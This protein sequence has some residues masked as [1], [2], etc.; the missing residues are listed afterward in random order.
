MNFFRRPKTLV[1]HKTPLRLQ[2]E[3]RECGAVCLGI[4]LA[5]Y[6]QYIPMDELRRACGTGRDGVLLSGIARAAR[7][8]GLEARILKQVESHRLYSQPLPF[9]IYWNFNHFLV[10]EGFGA[11]FLWVNDPVGGH[12]RLALDAEFEALYSGLV[13]HFQ[14][15]PDFQRGG[16]V[17]RLLPRLLAYLRPAGG[18]ILLWALLAALAAP[19]DIALWR[20]LLGLESAIPLG[21]LFLGRLGGMALVSILGLHIRARLDQSPALM[22]HL[23]KLPMSFYSA[24]YT[25]EISERGDLPYQIA[26]QVR[27]ALLPLLLSLIYAGGLILGLLLLNPVAGLVAGALAAAYGCCLLALSAEKQAALQQTG[28]WKA[29]L[30]AHNGALSG[31]EAIRQQGS[32]KLTQARIRDSLARLYT[33]EDKYARHLSPPL[34]LILPLCLVLASPLL[35]LGSLFSFGLGV[36]ILFSLSPWYKF[37]AVWLSLYRALERWEDVMYTP[38]PPP[39]VQVLPQLPLGKI[40]VRNLTFGYDPYRPPLLK[41]ISFSLEPGQQVALVGPSGEGKSTLLYLLAGLFDPWEGG[42]L[43][44]GQPAHRVIWER[45]LALVEASPVIF[46]GSVWDNLTLFDPSISPE[47]VEKA[48]RAALVY[49]VIHKR[50][51]GYTYQL[52]SRGRHFSAGE[53]QALMIARALARQPKLLLLDE[54]TRLLSQSQERALLQNLQAWPTTQILTSHRAS[55]LAACERVIYLSGGSL[56]GL[57]PH[58]ELMRR[59]DYQQMLGAIAE[60]PDG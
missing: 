37:F 15:R 43:V 23:M 18:A 34:G 11:D 52:D 2:M 9:M 13:L 51:G 49:E 42:V 41:E 5:Y 56:A 27:E 58:A 14:P 60:N 19:W 12:R 4:I 48:A 16:Q 21:L 31:I 32:E 50:Q 40:E 57:G 7:H 29:R 39:E 54:A 24:H 59:P 44:D 20:A 8:Y 26:K 10:V 38:P 46:D 22:A 1:R 17:P 30:N 53:L 3:S 35:A 28:Q 55:T 25:A 36:L 6:G 47:A 45:G 33:A